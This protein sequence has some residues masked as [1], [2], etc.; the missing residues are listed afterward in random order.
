[1]KKIIMTLCI[2]F[3]ILNSCSNKISADP[4]LRDIKIYAQHLTSLDSS[5]TKDIFKDNKVLLLVNTECGSC[6]Q[7][8]LFV[9]ETINNYNIRYILSIDRKRSSNPL[10][11]N[12]REENRKYLIFDM[13]HGLL[14]SNLSPDFPT[15][16]YLMDGEIKN[17]EILRKENYE[18]IKNNILNFAFAFRQ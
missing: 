7:N 13:R 12:I 10:L 5:S 3:W 1:M 14:R 18:E 6:M 15:V 17:A 16:L 4:G 9:M 11:L 8:S 2:W